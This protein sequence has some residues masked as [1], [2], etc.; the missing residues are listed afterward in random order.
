MSFG[1]DGNDIAARRV[2]RRGFVL[3]HLNANCKEKCAVQ[4]SV[5][6]ATAVSAMRFEVLAWPEIC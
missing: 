6:M 4:S 5:P 3:R 1:R 2:R